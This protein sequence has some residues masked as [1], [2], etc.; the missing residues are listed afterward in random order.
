MLLAALKRSHSNVGA[1]IPCCG[2][3]QVS[4][5]IGTLAVRLA[6]VEGPTAVKGSFWWRVKTSGVYRKAIESR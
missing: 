5:T 1:P 2:L 4:D 6:I 3:Y